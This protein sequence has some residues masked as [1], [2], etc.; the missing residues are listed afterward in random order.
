MRGR[1][2]RVDTCSFVYVGTY[3]SA[4]PNVSALLHEAGYTIGIPDEFR[5]AFGNGL[6]APRPHLFST[7]QSGLG[8]WVL[9]RGESLNHKRV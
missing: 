1:C 8:I 5:S 4:L 7:F 9:A 3:S 2:C 6:G